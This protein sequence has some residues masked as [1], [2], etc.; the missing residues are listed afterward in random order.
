MKQ[1]FISLI[2]VMSVTGLANAQSFNAEDETV[3]TTVRKTPTVGA[4]ATDNPEKC[5]FGT[6]AGTAFETAGTLVPGQ[7]EPTN[8]APSNNSRT[9]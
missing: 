3:D 4:F 9:N 6:N 5:Q 7:Q 2:F 1:F 8:T